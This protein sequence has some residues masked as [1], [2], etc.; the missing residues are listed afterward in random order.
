MARRFICRRDAKA[1][2]RP[3]GVYSPVRRADGTDDP[4]SMTDLTHHLDGTATYGHYLLDAESKV[5]LFCLDVDL[6]KTGGSWVHRPDL[7]ILGDTYYEP[8]VI[9]QWFLENTSVMP[10]ESP[11]DDWRNRAHPGRN[12]YKFQMRS[13]AE[14]FSSR[15]WKE[16]GIPVACSYTGNK[17]VHVYGFTGHVEAAVA[18]SAAEMVLQS[19]GTF[20]QMK[21]F[22]R[23]TNPDPVDGFSNFNIEVFPKQDTVKPGGYGNLLRLPLGVNRKNPV[24][25]CFFIDQRLA[26][27]TLRPHPDPVALLENG[28]PWKD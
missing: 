15:I 7:S 14:K 2:Q 25:P 11:R 26:H 17:G 9:E 5:K 20:E 23:D 6:N 1:T 13:I 8:D 21:G 3:D 24:D 28:N 19:F 12:W 27:D 18:A 10:S 22:W 16:L 4:W